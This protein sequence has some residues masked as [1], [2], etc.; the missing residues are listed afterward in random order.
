MA[1]PA[2]DVAYTPLDGYTAT[3]PPA[4]ADLLGVTFTVSKGDNL[5]VTFQVADLPDPGTLGSGWSAT[6]TVTLP[7][8]RTKPL[9]AWVDS[10][11]QDSAYVGSKLSLIHI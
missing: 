6:G 8:G 7:G 10:N 11:G 3:G 4:W 2:G 1:D 5:T 9:H